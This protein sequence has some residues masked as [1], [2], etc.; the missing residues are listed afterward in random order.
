VG[1][2]SCAHICPTGYIKFTDDGKTRQ[3]WGKTFK[4]IRCET[5]GQPTITEEFAAYLTKHRGIPQE[6][7]KRSDL[8]HRRELAATMGKISQWDRLFAS[9]A[10]PANW[11]VRSHMR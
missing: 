9:A 8:T 6:Y 3:I 10:G 1:C 2:L 4:L 11:P 7:F 5:T